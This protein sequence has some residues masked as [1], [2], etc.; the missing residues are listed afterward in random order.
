MITGPAS[1]G[2]IGKEICQESLTIDGPKPIA[3]EEIAYRCVMLKGFPKALLRFH[4]SSFSVE[5][6][7]L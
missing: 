5:V 3:D 4:V 7:A 2:K 1:A 6:R